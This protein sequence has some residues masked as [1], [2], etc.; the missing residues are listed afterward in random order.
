MSVIATKRLRFIVYNKQLFDGKTVDYHLF[1]LVIDPNVLDLQQKTG[2][3]VK[4][5]F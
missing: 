2:Q 4:L 1:I 3:K 5:H